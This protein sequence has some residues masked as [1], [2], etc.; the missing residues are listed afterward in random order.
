[1]QEGQ[2]SLKEAA[3]K[4]SI[5][6]STAKTIVQIF[7]K[8][9]RI[10]KKPKHMCVT[11][12]SL[13]RE[14]FLERALSKRRVQRAIAKI[15]RS[16]LKRFKRRKTRKKL[17]KD[18]APISERRTLAAT[19]QMMED[20]RTRG[21]PRVESAGQMEVFPDRVAG[22]GA[23]QTTCGVSANVGQRLPKRRV[24][25]VNSALAIEERYKEKIDYNNL[26]LLKHKCEEQ[27]QVELL[28][29][30]CTGGIRDSAHKATKTP[31][32][33]FEVDSIKLP[34]LPP[35][36]FVPSRRES[37]PEDSE[38]VFDFTQYST[39]IM[40]SIRER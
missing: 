27:F 28:A 9:R 38:I 24:F 19:G 11:K 39:M 17:P 37:V 22:P 3:R 5:N 14:E 33:S 25:Y 30:P 16:E 32:S 34:E 7:R 21:F 18:I 23:G 2:L 31:I 12:K 8:E 1:M 35:Y 36:N 29:A 13:R 40:A 6:Y 4:L 10:S 20:G 15:L 26:V